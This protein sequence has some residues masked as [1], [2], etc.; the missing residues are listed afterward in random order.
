MENGVGAA[1]VLE[2]HV[3]M[4][5]LQ[6]FCSIYSAKATAIS[7]AL[8][9]IKTRHIFKA[10]IL[11]DS[12]N[13]LRSIEK[14]FTPNEIA[15]K[16]QNQLHNFTKSEYS[17]ILIWISSHSQLTGNEKADGKAC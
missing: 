4:L 10:A 1:V 17:I 12:L 16:I 15:R 2:D 3:S 14:P 8:D 11:S 9:L 6:N 13:S 5:G 7:Y